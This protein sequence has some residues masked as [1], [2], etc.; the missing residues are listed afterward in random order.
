MTAVESVRTAPMRRVTFRHAKAVHVMAGA[1]RIHTATGIHELRSGS[2]LFLGAGRWCSIQPTPRVRTWTVYMDEVF[3]R[4]QLR[5]VFTDS[6]R[7]R[8]SISHVDDWDGSAFVHVVG[9]DALKRMEPLWRQI[10]LVSSHDN[11]EFAVTSLISLLAQLIEIA[12]PTVLTPDHPLGTLS[13]LPIKGRLTQRSRHPSVDRAVILLRTRMS[14]PWTI[15]L[16]AQEVAMSR[17]Q[18]SRT[19]SQQV[20]LSPFRFLTESR[21]T[22]FT[23]LVEETDL[24]IYVAARQVGWGDPR[25]AASWFRRRFGVSPTHFRSHPHASHTDDLASR[26]L[27]KHGREA[28]DA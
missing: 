4:S 23:R 22:E 10:S 5:W 3:L 16:L 13:P 14:D 8:E 21:L 11:P 7:L 15:S 26:R 2:V 18:L 24:P 12:L 25:V 28:A 17:S 9:Q 6:T 19:F 1:A 20:G 27:R